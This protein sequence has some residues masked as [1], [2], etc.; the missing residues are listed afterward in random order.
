MDALNALLRAEMTAVNQQFIHI[1]ALRRLGDLKRADRIYEV[2]RIDFPNVLRIIDHLVAT[3][4]PVALTPEMPDP[5][6]PT[7]GLLQAERRI[8]ERI[9]KILAAEPAA[10]RSIGPFFETA[11][12]P[13]DAYRIWLTTELKGEDD[14]SDPGRAYPAT[15]RLFSCLILILERMMV[16]AFVSFHEGA[17]AS[18]DIAWA[19]SGVAMV[20]ATALVN[21]L[22]DLRAIPRLSTEI[23]KNIRDDRDLI[24]AYADI[25]DQASLRETEESLKLIGTRAAAYTRALAAWQPAAPHPALAA[26][27]PSFKSFEATLKKFVWSKA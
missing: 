5:G 22:T 10:D 11:Q 18:A 19:T 6:L 23:R 27:A 13:P 16:G 26:C 17:R 2:D 3:G 12:A 25:A 9:A 14:R 20:Q 4:R 24:A 21:A 1:L 15:D 7:V 8:E